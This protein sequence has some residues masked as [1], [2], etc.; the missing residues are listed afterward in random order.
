MFADDV[1]LICPRSESVVLQSDIPAIHSWT[2]DGNL[3]LNENQCTIIS[4]GHSPPY[5][6]TRYPGGPAIKDV[7]RTNDLGVHVDRSFKPSRHCVLS[8]KTSLN[9]CLLA[10]RIY[11]NL[12]ADQASQEPPSLVNIHSLN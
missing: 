7:E 6:Y 11:G 2:Q 5:R 3:P 8:L 10:K 12:S 1:K 9:Y 4:V